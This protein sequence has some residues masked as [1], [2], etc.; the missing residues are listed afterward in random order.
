MLHTGALTLLTSGADSS[1]VMINDGFIRKK[2][3]YR[4]TTRLWDLVP[5]GLQA[6]PMPDPRKEVSPRR[7]KC[8]TRDGQGSLI[9]FK[10]SV[11]L[12]SVTNNGV[13]LPLW[14]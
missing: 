11:N 14:V 13:F 1:G 3:S 4:H 9:E 8:D 2:E 7:G 10:G 5:W 12:S 6:P